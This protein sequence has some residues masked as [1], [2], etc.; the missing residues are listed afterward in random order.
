MTTGAD[1]SIAAAGTAINVFDLGGGDINVTNDGSA[2]GASG[3]TASG[4]GAGNIT[5]ANDGH[6][7]GTSGV[8][9]GVTQA[10]NATGQVHIT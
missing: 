2:T 10:L 4:Y 7:T 9:I 1:S 3:L 8:G 6:I 5:I